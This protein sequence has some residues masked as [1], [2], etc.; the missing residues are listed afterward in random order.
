M[1]YHASCCSLF[2]GRLC[3]GCYAAAAAPYL[4]CAAMLAEPAVVTAPTWS[5]SVRFRAP[6]NAVEGM[7]VNVFCVAMN[8]ACASDVALRMPASL[9]VNGGHVCLPRGRPA[10]PLCITPLCG[11]DN[12]ATVQSDPGTVLAVLVVHS[13]PVSMPKIMKRVTDN[14]TLSPS[15]AA[16]AL[17]TA[18]RGLPYPSYLDVTQPG[19]GEEVLA[20]LAAGV[21]AVAPFPQVLFTVANPRS[22][23]LIDVPVR[24]I[25]CAHLQCFDLATHMAACWANPTLGW[26][27]PVCK[28]VRRGLGP[29]VAANQ[30]TSYRHVA[31]A[32]LPQAAPITHLVVDPLL[33]KILTEVYHGCR[34][35]H[36]A[37]P[38]GV[39]LDAGLHKLTGPHCVPSAGLETAVVCF[40]STGGWVL[41][42]K[43]VA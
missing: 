26:A 13:K 27:C 39:F 33:R 41:G 43:P 34:S 42:A 17:A 1:A 38:Q 18:C 11:S 29:R 19:K 21:S 16:C 31:S 28:Q 5:A 10:T 23:R 15:I 20:R 12:V 8:G 30:R 3:V 37:G 4:S 40:D 22:S 24:G 25:S 7:E 36:C 35:G 14:R 32:C 9:S 6:E 2:L